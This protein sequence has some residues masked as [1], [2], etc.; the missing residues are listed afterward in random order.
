VAN[1]NRE[2]YRFSTLWPMSLEADRYQFM[3]LQ[4]D[5]YGMIPELKALNPHLKILLYQSILYTNADDP[6]DMPTDT[7]CTSY[8]DDVANHPDWFLR[9]QNGN[10][11]GGSPGHYLMDVGAPAYQQACAANSA[12]LAT[13]LGFDGVFL[14]DVSGQLS[15]L[16]G[17]GVSVPKYS[18][19]DG[20]WVN[21][22]G[23]AIAYIPTVIDRQGL[24]AFGNVAGAPDVTTWEQWASH[25]DG[26]EEEAWTDGGLGL[27]QQVPY[28]SQKLAEL[29][30]TQANGKYEIVHSY[31]PSEAANTYGLASMLL[32]ATG[33]A[34]YSTSNANYTSSE[35][36]FPEYSQAQ[37]LGAPTGPYRVLGNGLYE[38]VYADGIVLV[39]PT[40]APTS[41]LSLGD[42]TYSGSHLT[43]VQFVQ[44]PAT[45]G[46]ILLRVS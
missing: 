22:I 8:A 10:S 23:S 28:W 12:A 17:A 18:A 16:A 3:V 46:L 2:T 44:V 5:W 27:S 7:G 4:G 32:A 26:I 21:A 9:D 45:S 20:G 13:R 36:W 19:Q 11:I 15:W 41:R 1:F 14:D 42:G 38:R 43:R 39:N 33:T 29:A 31:N 35:S 25:L 30:W 40:N 34:S 6:S 24:L 37:A